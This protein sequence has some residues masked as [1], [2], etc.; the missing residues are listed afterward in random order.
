MR[1][2]ET[3]FDDQPEP[4]GIIDDHWPWDD[5]EERIQAVNNLLQN[6]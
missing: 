4:G 6:G 1:V 2:T 5:R 3:V